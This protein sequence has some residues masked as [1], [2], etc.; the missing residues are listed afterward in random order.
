MKTVANCK[1]LGEVSGCDKEKY[2]ADRR[3]AGEY[4]EIQFQNARYE[5]LQKAAALGATHIVWTGRTQGDR[6][7]VNGKT[8]KCRD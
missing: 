2:T 6:P 8:Y 7:C 1:Y 4:S 5:A 3:T